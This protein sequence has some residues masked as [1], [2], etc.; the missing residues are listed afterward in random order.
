MNKDN[1]GFGGLGMEKTLQPD[2]REFPILREGS[3]GC[4]ALWL[5]NGLSIKQ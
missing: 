5:S 4:E 2:S 3:G 1:G